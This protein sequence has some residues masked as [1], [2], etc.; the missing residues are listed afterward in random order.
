[1]KH[2]NSKTV[3]SGHFHNNNFNFFDR[4][5]EQLC[6]IPAKIRKIVFLRDPLELRISMYKYVKSRGLIKNENIDYFLLKES[7]FIS[8]YLGCTTKNYK[9]IIDQFYF[10]GL[11]EKFVDSVKIFLL[12]PTSLLMLIF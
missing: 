11:T 10:I 12:K 1:M 7:N 5:N 8:N 2:F 3:I 4:Y 6:V 9:E